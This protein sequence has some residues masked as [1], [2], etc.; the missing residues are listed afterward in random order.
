M[1]EKNTFSVPIKKGLENGKIITHKIKVIDSFRFLSRSLSSLVD[2][3]S[4][5]VHNDK[6]TDC[7]SHLE[8]IS[9]EDELLIY[10]CLKCNK[11][12]KRRFQ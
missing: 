7:K 8:Y 1:L 3:L 6:C 11:S 10:N 5:G 4:E 9:T 12:H 2:D